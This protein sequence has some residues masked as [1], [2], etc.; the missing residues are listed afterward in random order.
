MSDAGPRRAKCSVCSA[1]AEAHLALLDE[2]GDSLAEVLGL[3]G[4]R[5]EIRLELELLRERVRP[6]LVEEPLRQRDR[7]RRAGGEPGG[8]RGDPRLERIRLDDLGDETP[9]VR[10]RRGEATVRRHPLEGARRAEQALDEV[11]PAGVRDQPDPDEAR[12]EERVVAR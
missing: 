12:Y 4:L 9:R 7:A 11:G 10:L 1:P 8:A 2:R 5:L 3:R 6:R